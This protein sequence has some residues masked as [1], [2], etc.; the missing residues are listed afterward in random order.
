MVAPLLAL[1]TPTLYFRA[2][3]ALPPTLTGSRGQ[4][5]NAI[6]GLLQMI[7]WLVQ[8][9]QPR[10][11]VA[12]L[13]ADWRPA[14]RVQALPSY[15]AHR[16]AEPGSCT[17]TLTDCTTGAEA[18]PEQLGEQVE[19]IAT[20][21]PALGIDCFGVAG[22]EADDV[23]ASIAAQYGRKNAPVEVVTGDRDLYQVVNDAAGVRVLSVTKGVAHYE[24]ID[25]ASL[26]QRY[27]IP[28]GCYV[29][30]AVLRG[31]PSDGLPGVTGIGEKTAARLLSTYGG[32]PQL[33]EAARVGDAGLTARVRSSLLQAR[34]YLDAA[35]VVTTT[36]TDVPLPGLRLGLPSQPVAPN[37]V[38]QL[39]A[40][41]NLGS[42]L[43]NLQAA[44]S[45]T[46]P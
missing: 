46:A 24:V 7:T 21:L 41:W 39:A 28:P 23:L 10:S 27:G 38:E 40:E 17:P 35:V 4:P 5:A 37:V 30:F 14:F 12:A 16:V 11:V 6:R 2:F 36:V 8:Q 9:R 32:L 18:V 25:E 19:A 15:K 45:D 42:V 34:D 13:D 3:Y 26:C 20:L 22:F 31:D 33:L 29:P 43:T 44:L 1:D